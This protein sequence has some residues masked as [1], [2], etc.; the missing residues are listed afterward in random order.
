MPI[1]IIAAIAKNNV[2]GYKNKIPWDIP[3]DK[4]HF[5]K[6][7]LGKVVIM[8]RKTFDSIGILKGRKNII[9]TRKQPV[10]IKHK[11]FF[12]IGGAE[13]YK[14]FLPFANKLYITQID[15]EY[16]GDTFFPKITKEWKITSKK[17]GKGNYHFL[18]YEKT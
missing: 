15:E 17:K 4:E 9:L 3:E 6:I 2:I 7:T 18:T 16:K 13:I 11:D 12:V 5:K 14:L 10:I 8:G 1:E